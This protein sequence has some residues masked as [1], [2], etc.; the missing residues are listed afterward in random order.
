MFGVRENSDFY[1][2]S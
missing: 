2:V 1:T